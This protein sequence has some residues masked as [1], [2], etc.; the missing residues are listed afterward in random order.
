MRK[1]EVMH[2]GCSP[3]LCPYL[4]QASLID[5]SIP[6][7][8]GWQKCIILLKVA[9]Q[10]ELI[11]EVKHTRYFRLRKYQE[12]FRRKVISYFSLLDENI[13]QLILKMILTILNAS[14]KLKCFP[15]TLVQASPWRSSW[16]LQSALTFF[17]LVVNGP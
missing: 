12:I 1:K 5:F 2:V 14:M 15:P 7:L 17:F 10:A 9:P 11:Q 8:G 13:F 3:S 6:F 4:W 16:F